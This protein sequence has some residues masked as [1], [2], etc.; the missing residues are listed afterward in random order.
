M[1]IKTTNLFILFIEYSLWWSSLFTLIQWAEY[2][3]KLRC[4]GLFLLINI[5]IS[6]LYIM[7]SS[8]LS[9][10][11]MAIS[12]KIWLI[13]FVLLV[14]DCLFIVMYISFW[15]IFMTRFILLFLLNNHKCILIMMKPIFYIMKMSFHYFHPQF[16]RLLDLLRTL[17]FNFRW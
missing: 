13:M 2:G 8:C 10:I 11:I 7:S 9:L 5:I 4:A 6:G 17:L 15:S 3:T 1:I 14:V 12:I 16:N